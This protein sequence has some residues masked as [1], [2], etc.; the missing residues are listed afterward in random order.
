M[1]LSELFILAAMI[2]VAP[3]YS[4]GAGFTTALFFVVAALVSASK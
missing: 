1:T 2:F 4:K 3:H